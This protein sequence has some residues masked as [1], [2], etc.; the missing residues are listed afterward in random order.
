ML[1]EAVTVRVRRILFL[2]ASGIGQDD[3]AQILGP[4]GAEHAAAEALGYEPRQIAAMIEVGMGEDDGIDVRRL[5][6]ELLPVPLAQL[7]EPLEQAGIDQHLCRACIE[8][9]FGAGDGT[10]RTQERD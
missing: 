7:L 6:R 9:I 10:C 4:G 8:Q 5:D 3:P 1:R 2:D